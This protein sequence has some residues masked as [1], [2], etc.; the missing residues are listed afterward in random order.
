[1]AA[2]DHSRVLAT[3]CNHSRVSGDGRRHAVI[4]GFPATACSYSK[5]PA[6]GG[7]HAINGWHQSRGWSMPGSPTWRQSPP[8]SDMGSNEKCGEGNIRIATRSEAKLSERQVGEMLS[9]HALLQFKYWK[10]QSRVSLDVKQIMEEDVASRLQKSRLISRNVCERTCWP[11]QYDITESTKQTLPCREN[12]LQIRSSYSMVRRRVL[13]KPQ[14][15]E[16]ARVTIS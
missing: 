10:T 3:A 7:G 2:Y 5:V 15:F 11:I 8:P 16:N 6:A 13:Q 12:M 9:D 1:M 14:T 4:L